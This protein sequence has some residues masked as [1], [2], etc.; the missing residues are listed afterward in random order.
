MVAV[1]LLALTRSLKPYLRLPGLFGDFGGK[2]GLWGLRFG[3]P[4]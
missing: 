1:R 4:L 2:V 3:I